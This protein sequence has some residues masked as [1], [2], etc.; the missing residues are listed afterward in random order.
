MITM[1]VNVDI[2][3]FL[4][5]YFDET[6]TVRIELKE[7]STVRDLLTHLSARC[8][9][10]VLDNVTNEVELRRYCIVTVGKR[11][12]NLDDEIADESEIIKLIPPIS[13]G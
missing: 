1:Q 9:A 10:R 2:S 5:K 7:N 6:G 3:K 12:A 8:N 4:G 13:G 11:F